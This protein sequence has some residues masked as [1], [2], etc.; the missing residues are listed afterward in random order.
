MNESEPEDHVKTMNV[1]EN[2]DHV[3]QHQESNVSL[4]KRRRSDNLL[5]V[6]QRMV[7]KRSSNEFLELG[8]TKD[9][10]TKQR[11]VSIDFIASK[12]QERICKDDA[13]GIG[14]KEKGPGKYSTSAALFVNECLSEC[15][16]FVGR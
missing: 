7:S 16:R 4:L 6:D 1:S 14:N 11:R 5:S 2:C 10:E 3:S 12:A 15:F 9:A 13:R 8:S